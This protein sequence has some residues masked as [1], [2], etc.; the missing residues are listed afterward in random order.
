MALINPWAT[1]LVG[2]IRDSLD[3]F[4][5]SGQRDPIA[6]LSLSGRTAHLAGLAER[7]TTELRVPVDLL[8]PFARVDVSSRLRDIDTRAMSVATGL[9][10]GA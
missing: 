1:T 6:R 8:D 4:A 10:M 3:Y 2:A 7:V 5:S 9:A